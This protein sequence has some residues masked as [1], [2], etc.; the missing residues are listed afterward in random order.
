LPIANGQTVE[1]VQK[2]RAT[3]GR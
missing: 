3:S 1:I 2:Y